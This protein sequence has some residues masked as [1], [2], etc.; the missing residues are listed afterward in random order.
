MDVVVEGILNAY[1]EAFETMPCDDEKVLK[2]IEE[3]KKELT[4]LAESAK[5]VT[6]FMA[7][8][9]SKGYGKRYIDLF[10]KIAMSKSSEITVEEI[11]KRQQITPKEFVEQYRTAYDAIKA[12]KYRKK[13]EQAYQNLFDL[14]EQSADML[15]FN[16]ESE[17]RNLMFKLSADDNIEQNEIIAQASDPLDKIAYPQYA[18]TIENWQNAKSDADI[19]YLSE[20]EQI[21]ISQNSIR[22]QQKMTLIATITLLATEFIQ[23]KHLVLSGKSKQN[24]QNGLQ[25]M[26]KKRAD[27]KR[28]FF[29]LMPAFEL[30]WELILNDKFYRHLLLTPKNLDVTGRITMCSHP[31]NIE[32]INEI[33]TEEM[34]SD[35]PIIELVFRPANT[36]MVFSTH[37]RTDEISS[38]YAKIAENMNKDLDYYKYVQAATSEPEFKQEK[39]PRIMSFFR[40]N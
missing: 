23:F 38:K 8:Y 7:D 29:D 33:V 17:R 13:A 28:L 39:S 30:S 12:C 18:R 10:G 31:Q 4:L 11:E 16:I 34:L 26:I 40:K 21:K 37:K 5:D 24:I 2:E 14:A 15:D 27:L 3:F 25:G 20:V 6:S 9:D 32:A 36:P 1:L 19:T 35:K 22:E